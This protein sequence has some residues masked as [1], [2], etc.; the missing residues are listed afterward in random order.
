MSPFKI[1]KQPYKFY[2][3][4]ILTLVAGNLL[5]AQ[6]PESSI[7]VGDQAPSFEGKDQLGK[8]IRSQEL[9]EEGPT[10]VLFYRGA[11]CPYCRKH[12]KSLQDSLNMLQSKN[13]NVIAITPEVEESVAKTIKKTEAV[14]S[15]IHDKNY[16][17]MRAFGVDFV[18]D[19]KTVKKYKTF[20]I[21]LTESNGNDDNILP[22]PATFLID[23][24]G[25][26]AYVHYDTNYKKRASVKDIWAIVSQLADN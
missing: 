13:I 4:G 1:Q 23:Q 7:K 5:F 21:N 18:V 2:F 12:L 19:D 6:A 20:G 15:I 3:L 17:I 26:V 8:V 24:S 22:V 16:Q 25:K 9:L 14:F 11:W 10:L